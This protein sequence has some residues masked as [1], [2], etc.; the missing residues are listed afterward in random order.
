[1]KGVD[2]IKACK[3]CMQVSIAIQRVNGIIGRSIKVM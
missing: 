1:M 2:N 3:S